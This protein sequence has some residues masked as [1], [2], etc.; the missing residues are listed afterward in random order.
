MMT[1]FWNL[2]LLRTGPERMPTAPAFIATVLVLDLGLNVT[3]LLPSNRVS[4]AGVGAVF[5]T[6]AAIALVTYAILSLKG[7]QSRFA[8]TFVAIVGSDVII[9]TA[10]LLALGLGLLLGTLVLDIA[11][12]AT[13]L[14][15]L[16]VVGFIFQRALNVQRA[17]G[18]ALG[19]LLMLIAVLVGYQ[20]NPPPLPPPSA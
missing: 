13:L 10:Q 12:F 17:V 7:L 16:V 19:I 18:I 3:A 20:I 9:T 6:T 4:A 14:W 11:L 1:I 8:A 2:C 15:T 5:A